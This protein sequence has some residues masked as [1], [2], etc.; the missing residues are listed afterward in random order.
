MEHEN[1]G[2]QQQQQQRNNNNN[3]FTTIGYSSSLPVSS[4]L[5]V[6]GVQ[7]GINRKN[8]MGSLSRWF[9]VFVV[10][11]DY[12]VVVVSF[13]VDNDVFCGLFICLLFACF[14]ESNNNFD[15][16]LTHTHLHTLL[17]KA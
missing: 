15:F 7:Q 3:A 4:H 13:F 8:S 10:V 1:E 12:C 9:F 5:P 2:L 14:R 17:F 6:G 11:I 16:L